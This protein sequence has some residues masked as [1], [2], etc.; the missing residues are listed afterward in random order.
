MD[1]PR[2]PLHSRDNYI[3]PEETPREYKKFIGIIIGTLLLSLLLTF[4][5]GWGVKYLFQD[6]VAAFLIF[7]AGYKLFRLE[8]FSTIYK[9]YDII[10]SRWHFWSYIYPFIELALGANYLLSNGSVELD[11]FTLLIM[12]IA[13]YSFI[14]QPHRRSHIQYACLDTTIRLPLAT[15][16]VVESGLVFI[17]TLIVLLFLQH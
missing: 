13:V 17:M 12:G 16:S 5:R 1:R 2:Q 14:K 7:S 15:I 11:I 3:Y 10:A 4:G 8:V 9:S 6:F